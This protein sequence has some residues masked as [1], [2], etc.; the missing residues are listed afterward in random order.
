MIGMLLATLSE[1]RFAQVFVSVAFVAVLAVGAL[2][3]RWSWRANGH[4][5]QLRALSAASEFWI[6]TLALA[7]V[8]VTTF[9]LAFF[10]AAGM[11]TFTSENRSTPLRICMLVQQAALVGWMAYRL[12]S[13]A[14]SIWSDLSSMAMLAGDL[15]VRDG[16]AADRRAPGNVAAR[17]AAAAEQLSGP[18]VSL[19]AESGPGERLHV[20]RGQWHARSSSSACLGMMAS[21]RTSALAADVWPADG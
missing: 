14:T 13:R 19:V 7:T 2:A 17:E 8:Y 5:I 21:G 10:A 9:A 3:C 6:V 18:G 1:Q 16:H 4:S 20:R 11:I 12:D 15:L